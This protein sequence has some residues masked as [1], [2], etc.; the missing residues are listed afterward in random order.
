MAMPLDVEA[1]SNLLNDTI[2]T[3]G[4]TAHQTKFTKERMHDHYFGT[5][6]GISCV[7]AEID[8]RLVGF[9]SLEWSDPDWKGPGQLPED[10]AIIATFVKQGM[11]GV[12]IGSAL[13]QATRI[14]AENCGAVAIDATIRTD[15]V[16]GLHYYSKLGFVDYKL[17]ENVPL[18][19]GTP[20]DR[21]SKR[22]DL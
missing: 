6:Y 3:G 20:V 18:T 2:E 21:I 12:G 14:I 4:S 5:K 8:N 10:W 16:G 7:V 22:Y 1:M 19:D 13:F 11:T 15:N 9:Q 17:S